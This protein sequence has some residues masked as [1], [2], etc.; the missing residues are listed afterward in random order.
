MKEQRRIFTDL[1]IVIKEHTCPNIINSF[2]AFITEQDVCI[3]MEPMDTCLDKLQ[4][5]LRAKGVQGPGSIPEN[6]LGK[7]TVGVV[8]GLDF[9]KR[10]YSVIHRDVK[11]SNILIDRHGEVKIC[12]FGIAGNL[13]DSKVKT[14]DQGCPAYMSPERIDPPDQDNPSYDIRA[15]VWSLGITLVELAYCKYPYNH[16]SVQFMLMTEIINEP[17][18]RLDP[19]DQF[20]PEFTDFVSIILVKD[21]TVR[22]KYDKLLQHAFVKKYEKINKNV[23]ANWYS[24]NFLDE[25]N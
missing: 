2:G 9:L 13:V 6:V 16:T 14:R 24:S 10:E 21:V 5:A 11:P 22:P 25:D 17:A 7:I 1:N 12:D 18:P 8:H 3:C 20:S 19:K 15:D 23:V 4:R